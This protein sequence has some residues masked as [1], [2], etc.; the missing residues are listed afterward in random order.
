MFLVKKIFFVYYAYLYAGLLS[1]V[2]LATIVAKIRKLLILKCNPQLATIFS[3]D[4]AASFQ[5]VVDIDV[6]FN[7]NK[8]PMGTR[9]GNVITLNVLT[10]EISNLCS[11]VLVHPVGWEFVDLNP[12]FAIREINLLQG[13]ISL[14][15]FQVKYAP[16]NGLGAIVCIP[17]HILLVLECA[18]HHILIY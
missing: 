2:K 15:A 7:P 17:E 13:K 9:V 11:I 10:N 3:S 1:V 12:E 6:G 5:V 14:P 8:L 16:F 18:H 4:E